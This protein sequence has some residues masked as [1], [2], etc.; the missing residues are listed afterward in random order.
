MNINYQQ[1]LMAIIATNVVIKTSNQK[2]IRKFI[3]TTLNCY[4]NSNTAEP[5]K[6]SGR[7]SV[8]WAYV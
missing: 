3:K 8:V 7:V 1:V 2:V 6:S 4:Y 5:L